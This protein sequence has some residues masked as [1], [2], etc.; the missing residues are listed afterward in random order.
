MPILKY[1]CRDCGNEFAKIF[2]DPKDAPRA[3]P[4]CGAEELR[5]L[6]EAFDYEGISPQRRACIS[7]EACG[8]EEAMCAPSAS[9]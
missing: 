9:T 8:E 3:C 4:V 6:G 7:C 1:Q 2:F 5:E